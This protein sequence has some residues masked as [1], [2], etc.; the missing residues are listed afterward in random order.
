M[1]TSG[2]A[3]GIL[4]G[5]NR[6]VRA[7]LD[8][9]VE[10][11]RAQAQEEFAFYQALEE[12]ESAVRG[13][14]HPVLGALAQ[15]LTDKR[16]KSATINWQSRKNSRAKMVAMVKVLLA[17]HKYPP[18]KQPEAIAK[19]FAQAELLADSWAG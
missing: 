14:G 8:P 18:D 4:P 3:Q 2:A 19:V 10:L 11:T 15:E 17:T 9:A 1:D 6:G 12:N 13:L 16:R 7:C 5:R